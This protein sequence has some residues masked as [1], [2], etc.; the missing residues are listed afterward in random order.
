MKHR[1]LLSFLLLSAISL[2]AANQYVSPSGDD[3]QDG[4]SWATAKQSIQSAYPTARIEEKKEE[5]IFVYFLDTTDQKLYIQ[6]QNHIPS[7][8]RY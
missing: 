3:A 2:H 8:R 6:R 7:R 4:S 1:F 5:N